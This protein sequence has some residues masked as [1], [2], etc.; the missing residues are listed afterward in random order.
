VVVEPGI[1]P[2]LLSD[3][4]VRVPDLAVICAPYETE[5]AVLVAPVLL[6]EILSPSNHGQAWTNLRRSP[7]GDLFRIGLRELYRGRDSRADKPPP[8]SISKGGIR[9]TRGQ[10]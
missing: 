5:E 4:N 6:I 10:Q 3:H 2:R 1:V 7:Q 9:G 8:Q